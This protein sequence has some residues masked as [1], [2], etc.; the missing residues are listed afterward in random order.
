MGSRQSITLNGVRYD[1]HTGERLDSVPVKRDNLMTQP[2]QVDNDRH[3][4][5]KAAPVTSI[6]KRQQKSNALRRNYLVKPESKTPVQAERKQSTGHI[7]RST[8][9]VRFASHPKTIKQVNDI[10]PATPIAPSPRMQAAL[11][12]VQQQSTIKKQNTVSLSSMDIKH[13]LIKAAEQK[14][15]VKSNYKS[16][17]NK[18]QPK[19]NRKPSRKFFRLPQAIVAC[20]ALA[21]LG[22]YLM[23][24]NMPSLSVKIASMQSGVSATFPNYGPDG[25]SFAGPIE[26]SPGEV[27]LV[28]TANGGGDGYSINQKSSGWNSVA[29][30]DNYVADDSNGRYEIEAKNG[31]ILYTYDNKVVWSNGG[32]LYTIQAEAP[33]SKVQLIDIAT[34]M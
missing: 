16:V 20:F 34:S 22:G 11:Q 19:T 24:I 27:K 18:S 25:Y 14:Q 23:Y 9:I 13:G 1:A 6:H 7:A 2:V 29:V 15:L 31:I 32:I 5:K 12:R 4:H 17:I 3:S 8:N 26:Y 21:L 33:L 28:F 30:L 10:S